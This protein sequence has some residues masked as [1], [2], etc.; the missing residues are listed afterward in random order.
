M[1]EPFSLYLHIPFCTA[2][3]GYCDFNSYAGQDHLIPNYSDALVQEARLWRK[4][5]Q[6][7]AVATVF[8]GGGT[9]SLMPIDEFASIMAGVRGA[10][11]VAPDA[12]ISLEA[13]PG[14]LDE[15][16]LRGL[17]ELG[18]NRLSIGVQSFHNDELSDLD[19][20]HSSADAGAA[21]EAARAAGFRN[22][23]LDLIFGLPDQPLERWQHSV[24][25]ALRLDPEHI[26]LYALTV[27]AGTPLARSVARGRTPA[28]VPDAQAD[29]Y[30]WTVERLCSTDFEHYEI[31]N[32]AKE[33]FRCLH[34]LTYWQ[35]RDYLGLGAGAHSYL[36]GVRFATAALPDRYVA[37]VNES[38]EAAGQA[39]EGGA[40]DTP[41]RQVVTGETMTPEL[42]ISDTLILGLRLT[43]GVSLTAF[44]ERFGVGVMDAAGDA[45]RASI[46]DGLAEI[47]DGHV[48]L[49]A[50]GRMLGNEVFER[51]LPE[52]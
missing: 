38:S 27:E 34:N 19:R 12:E 48:R 42:E 21:F 3:C 40:G 16:Y 41:M 52:G 2:K 33:G 45:V 10:F 28:P 24:E 15:V 25:E 17:L 22:V 9:P 32:W 37:L 29:Q 49:T 43:Q 4:A 14:S 51:L 1:T 26:S 46:D 50:R 39:T 13:N 5:T 20:I 30:E 35:C 7:R 6:G 23:S 36:D 47:A 8:F 18:V 44:E 11:D 31:S